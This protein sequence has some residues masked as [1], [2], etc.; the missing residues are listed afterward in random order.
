MLENKVLAIRADLPNLDSIL[1]QLEKMERGSLPYTQEAVKT[2]TE[3]VQRRWIDYISGVQVVYSGGTFRVRSV[4]GEYMRS[5]VDGLSYPALGDRLTGEVTSLSPHGRIVE[6]GI[7]PFDMKQTHLNGPKAKV[8]ASGK[9][10]VTVPFRHNVP[11]QG[12]TANA[13]PEAV[14]QKAKHLAVSRR[15]G[16][17]R[18]WWTGRKYTWGDRLPA[19]DGGAK[20]KPHWSTGRYT[21]MVKAGAPGHSQYLTFRRLSENSPAEAW[22]HPGKEPRPVTEA[23]TENSRQEVI[24]LIRTGF[25]VDLA[26]LP[27]G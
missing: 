21:G 3:V 19:A 4:T 25:E 20:E 22:Q 1:D 26:T 9:K 15:N 13:M 2:A 8:G 5:V 24:D 18:T 14:Y 17:L 11:G 6:D 27:F 16:A 12:V 23:V 7:K 10:Y